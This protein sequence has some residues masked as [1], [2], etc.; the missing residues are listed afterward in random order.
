M[1]KSVGNMEKKRNDEEMQYLNLISEIM[2]TQNYE[3]SRN[4]NT[5]S[6]FGHM[7]RFSLKDGSIP[8]LTTKKVQW[9]VCFEELFWFIKGKTD[10][11]LLNE[12]NVNI[13]NENSTVE[14]LRERGLSYEEGDLGPIYGHQ[15]RHYNAKYVNCNTCYDNQGIDQLAEIIENLKDPEKR[16][17]RRLVLSAWNPCQ[18]S[19]M[20]LPPCHMICQF[21]VREEKYLSC[22]L[23]QRSGDV[24]LGIPF[25]IASYSLFTHILAKHTGLIADEFVHFIG[26][27]HIYEEHADVLMMQIQREPFQFP[28]IMIKNKKENIDDYTVEDI[29]WIIPYVHHETIK[30]RMKA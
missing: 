16:N 14:F 10:N 12:K 11:Q 15:W 13:W 29:E 6:K 8:L 5:F 20:A 25:N 17:S 21:N 19:E 22:A 3:K 4:G 23:F 24:G 26:N 30:M 7:M 2:E 9:R 1:E 18:L 28:R 27:A